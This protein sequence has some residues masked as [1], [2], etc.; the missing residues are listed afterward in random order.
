M[1][2]LV[3]KAKKIVERIQVGDGDELRI[4][5]TGQDLVFKDGH[6]ILYRTNFIRR[7]LKKPGTVTFDHDFRDCKKVTLRKANIIVDGRM[8]FFMPEDRDCFKMDQ[9][10]NHIVFQYM[11]NKVAVRIKEYIDAHS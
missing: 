2:D 9:A 10:P 5:G 3:D 8:D 11:Y 1:N 4:E 7:M 6:I